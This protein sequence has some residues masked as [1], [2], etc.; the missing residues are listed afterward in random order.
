MTEDTPEPHDTSV[1]EEDPALP[2]AIDEYDEEVGVSTGENGTPLS[3]T[4]VPPATSGKVKKPDTHIPPGKKVP[5]HLLEKRRL[6]RIKAAEEFAKKLKTIGIEKRDNSALQQ[7]GLFKPLLLINQKNYSSDYLKKDDQIFAMRERK[8]LRNPNSGNGN[9][10]TGN[11]AASNATPEVIPEEEDNDDNDDAEGTD[12]L[13]TIVIHPGSKFLKIGFATDV[14]PQSVPSCIAIPRATENSVRSPQ[15]REPSEFDG[16]KSAIQQDFKERMRYY[17]RKVI[18]NAHDA[19]INFNSKVEPELIHEHNDLHRIE[20]IQNGSNQFYGEEA[21]RCLPSHFTLRYPFARGSFNVESPYYRSFQELLGD[22]QSLLEYCL[23][24]EKIDVTKQ[25]FANYKIVLVIPDLYDKNYVE[26]FIH[27]LLVQMG[28]QAVA[29]IQESLATTYGAGISNSTCVV[30]IGA[31]STKIACVDEGTVLGNSAVTLDYGGDDITRLFSQFLLQ[32]KFPY[33]DWDLST[34][35]GW[36]LA[37]SLK[38]EFTT[39][40]DAN[41]AVQ[42]YNFIKRTPG[43]A[44]AQKYE[45]KVFDEV[46]LAPM[47]MFF[48]KILSLLNPQKTQQEHYVANQFP[49]SKDIYT[50]RDN[51]PR[52]ISQRE[53]HE[54]KT[55]CDMTR[56][57]DILQKI[58]NLPDEIDE[59]SN[60]NLS[61]KH[62]HD[63]IT[64]LEKAIVESITN[65]SISLDNNMSRLGNFYSNLLV[66]GGGSKFPSLDFIL[67]DRINIWR[68]RLLSV[69]TISTFYKKVAQQIKDFEQEN[70]VSE[71]TDPEQLATLKKK[72]LKMVKLELQSYWESVDALGGNENV[73][74]INVLPPPRDM[75][76]AVL[77]WKGGSVLA[78]IKLV[79]ELYITAKDWD[80]LGSRILQYKCIFDY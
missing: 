37:E 13:N 38:K 76:P 74:P 49:R 5:M 19:V 11:N 45:F 48:P 32:S 56:D 58:L 77:T 54:N 73:F 23:K 80:V 17:K 26:T 10:N 46:M 64:P 79:E 41:V 43:E 63:N 36:M 28:F 35:H 78:R 22:V 70:K 44:D 42:L 39:F 29:I 6:G 71:V 20:W 62:H 24:Q 8:S 31:T 72:L 4:P 16:L 60:S 61:K 50:L 9:G 57:L 1:M 66:V 2:D 12:D 47:A 21:T 3:M 55:Y 59:Y 15:I 52:S 67:T 18:P 69:N 33:D 75:D 51:N 14:L 7:T 25:Q 53:C 34:P 27:L 30:D 40:Q 68:P 65:A